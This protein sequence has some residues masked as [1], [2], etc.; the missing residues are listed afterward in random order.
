MRVRQRALA[1][2][3][4]GIGA[5]GGASADVSTDGGKT[6]IG[7]KT[8]IDFTNI[9]QS[10]DGK[11]SPANGTGIDV[12]RFYLSFDHS[13]DAVWS[14]NFM[15]DFNY[16]ST[17][18]ETQVFVKTVY[19]QAKLSDAFVA[20]AGSAQLPWV[21]FVEDLYGY[22]YVE[23][24]LID[25]LNFGTTTDWGVHA[26]G[27]LGDGLAS[28]AVSV[29]NGGGFKNPTRSKSMDVEGR[30][31]LQPVAGLTIA[32]GLHDGKL[33]KDLEGAPA[34]H[35]AER[36]DAVIGY[37]DP[38]FR[39]GAE[40]FSAKNWNQV[41][42]AATDKSDGISGWVSI[43]PA[44]KFSFFARFDSAKPSKDLAPALKDTYYNVG[45]AYHV[46]K[47]IDA[48]LVGKHEEIKH[49]TF[50]TANGTIGGTNQ[51]KYNEI[52]V[53]TFVQY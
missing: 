43:N 41:L 16:V 23:K 36:W 13:F 27:K 8:F 53:W 44:E 1:F 12:K 48:A 51:G 31:G 4:A 11:A 42:K 10:S 9:D 25:R 39:L 32:F 21:P 22:R 26:N 35:S 24:L 7:A 5:S 46:R 19:L 2:A 14:A 6:T 20:R 45:V 50:A 29:V 18:G 17:D 15:T 52:G 33:G 37:V 34:L 40:Y 28:Y 30:V 49:G 47:G 38:R 3:I